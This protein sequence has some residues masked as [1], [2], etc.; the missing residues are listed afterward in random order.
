MT[1]SVQTIFRTSLG[2]SP[3]P[4][5]HG[6]HL[7][8]RAG[9]D[10]G[11][12]PRWGWFGSGAETTSGL[13]NL[14]DCTSSK[15]TYSKFPAH[16]KAMFMCRNCSYTIQGFWTCVCM[17]S[18]CSSPQYKCV[19]NFL[20]ISRPCFICRKFSCT[21]QLHVLCV[22][23]LPTQFKVIGFVYARTVNAASHSTNV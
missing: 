22:G 8:S 15:L 6:S 23:N 14:F 2:P 21:F 3:K 10:T 16:F 18:Q 13:A 17:Y 4:P 7:V 19:G 12:D 11:S 1:W 20:H 5:Q 9:R